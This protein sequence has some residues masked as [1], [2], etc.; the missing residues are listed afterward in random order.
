MRKI[1]RLTVGPIQTNC[2]LYLDGD[3]AYVIDP[4]D[5]APAIRQAL[6][7]LDAKDYVVLLTHAHFDHIMALND[8]A[9]SAIYAHVQEI[10]AL[11]D[12]RQNLSGDI[13][14]CFCTD[15]E[16]TSLADGDVVGPFCALHTPGHRPG[17]LCFYDRE[18]GVL[19]SGDTLFA[20]GYG[21]LD[22]P[23][24]QPEKMEGSLRRLLALPASTRVYPGHGGATT[25]GR[26][27][28]GYIL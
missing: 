15:K 13:G 23:G 27:A 8:L 12:A 5:E 1:E 7:D 3:R 20:S 22:L 17:C 18:E 16:V 10:P 6:Q 14:R 21:R 26:E 25:I 11:R 9:P 19:F 4:G 24:A 2:Y 28:K